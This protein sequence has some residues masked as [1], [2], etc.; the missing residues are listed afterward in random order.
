MILSEA[1]PFLLVS[2]NKTATSS[3]DVAL[4]SFM[5]DGQLRERAKNIPGID[6]FLPDGE[7]VETMRWNEAPGLKHRPARWFRE[8]LPILLPR[9]EWDGLFKFCFVR[10]PLERLRSIYRFHLQWLPDV[11]PQVVELGSFEAWLDYGGTGA[12][13]RSMRWWIHDEDGRE[14]VDFVGRFEQLQDD[15]Q[16]VTD[17][18]GLGPVP[19]GHHELTRTR[20]TRRDKRITR[21]MRQLFLARPGWREDLEYFGYSL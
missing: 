19:L 6:E 8:Q 3:M 10:H 2:I 21:R 11:Y 18:L 15:W 5:D 13:R 9:A 12:A 16:R 1:P 4:G 7:S 17:R 20:R 14:L